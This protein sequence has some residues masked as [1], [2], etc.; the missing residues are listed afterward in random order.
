M[1]R[2]QSGEDALIIDAGGGT[3]DISAYTVLNGNPLQVEELYEP[4]C[5]SE[6]DRP[7]LQV[8]PFDTFHFQACS[9]VRS[10]SRRGQERWFKVRS[11]VS[12]MNRLPNLQPGQ[13]RDSR[14]DTP[15][16]LAAFSQ[17]FDEGL[18]RV[19]SGDQAPQYV[20]FGSPRDNDPER[21]IKAG[22]LMLTG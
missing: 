22:R 16:D 5:E 13:L 14:F 4:K 9:K 17:R 18:K 2:P 12:P 10:L 19:F 21:G 15:E 20:K 1:T 3:I 6:S 8:F 7:Q 11:N